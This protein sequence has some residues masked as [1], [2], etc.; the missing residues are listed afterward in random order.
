[1]ENEVWKEIDGFEG[2]YEVS[3]K[4]EIR[5]KRGLLKPQKNNCGY[6]RVTLSK[7]GIEK[8]YFVHR[9]VAE[10]FID[11][12]EQFKCVNHKDENKLN[13][14]CENLEWCDHKYNCNY[15]TKVGRT[16]QAVSKPVV[17]YIKAT[18]AIEEYGS[19]T[20]ATKKLSGRN[21]ATSNICEAIKGKR[22]TAFGR[23]W[24]YAK[25]ER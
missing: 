24:E 22:K 7:D 21:K 9:I 1:M 6:Y 10:T 2:L 19:I 5:S 17:A 18:G 25:E 11:N 14:C 13:N 4:G 8:R 12:E 20:E 23:T 15:G 3:N 16:S